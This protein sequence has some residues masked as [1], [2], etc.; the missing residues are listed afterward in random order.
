LV[1]TEVGGKEFVYIIAEEAGLLRA[2]KAYIKTGL[3]QGGKVVVEEGLKAGDRL[4]R[5]GAYK[6]VENQPLRLK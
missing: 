1:Q 5:D 2:K 3:R 4:I 6:V